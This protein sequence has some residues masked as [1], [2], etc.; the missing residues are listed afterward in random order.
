MPAA[1]SHCVLYQTAA[2]V[3]L[4]PTELKKK[5]VFRHSSFHTLGAG[6]F[7]SDQAD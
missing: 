3:L 1:G 7:E 2:G 4:V 6:Q 5:K